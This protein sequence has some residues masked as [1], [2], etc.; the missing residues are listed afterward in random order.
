MRDS[1]EKRNQLAELTGGLGDFQTAS[2]DEALPGRPGSAGGPG[3]HPENNVI[4]IDRVNVGT[5]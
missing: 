5:Q 4:L 2:L 1:R 3:M